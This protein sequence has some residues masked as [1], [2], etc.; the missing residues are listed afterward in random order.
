MIIIG[1]PGIGKSTIAAQ[2]IRFIDLESSYFKNDSS[3]PGNYVKFAGKLSKEGRY[4]FVSSHDEVVMALKAW[5][6]DKTE[7]I[8][9][10]V[11]SLD[12]KDDW[13]EMLRTRLENTPISTDEW[14]KNKRAF[15]RASTYYYSDI[16][17]VLINGFGSIILDSLQD[18]DSIVK[19]ILDES[20][21]WEHF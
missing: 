1:Y 4:V 14:D 17:L 16:V 6:I 8:I 9:N 18:R 21:R 10:V 13:I 2:D 7:K 3:W 15:E 5:N 20:E 11:P 12:I 19:A